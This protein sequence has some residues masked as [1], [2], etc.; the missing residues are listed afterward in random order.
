MRQSGAPDKPWKP[1]FL[2]ADVLEPEG[3]NPATLVRQIL[4][5]IPQV[6]GQV[7]WGCRAGLWAPVT[8]WKE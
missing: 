6:Q 4:L 5:W 8:L 1:L 7:P 3:Q 2:L